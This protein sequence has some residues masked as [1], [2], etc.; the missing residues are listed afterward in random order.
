ME[1][2]SSL[3][4]L[5][6]NGLNEIVDIGIAALLGFRELLLN[7]VVSIVLQIFE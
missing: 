4:Q 1:L 5:F 7:Q 6:A 2:Q 3:L